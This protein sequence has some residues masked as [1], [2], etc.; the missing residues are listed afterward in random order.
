MK[1]VIDGMLEEMIKFLKMCQQSV[2]QDLIDIQEYEL[3]VKNKI[4]FIND[5]LKFEDTPILD[6]YSQELENVLSV[7]KYI[8]NSKNKIC[9]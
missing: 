9:S 8:Y 2:S 7:D 4:K 5:M 3:L 1:N 6:K